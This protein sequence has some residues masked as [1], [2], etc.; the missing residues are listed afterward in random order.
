VAANGSIY[1]LDNN[2][3]QVVE[4]TSSGRAV[5]HWPAPPSSTL[6]S[7]HVLALADGRVLVTDPGGSILLYKRPGASAVRLNLVLPANGT[8]KQSLLGISLSKKGSLL[9]TDSAG[10]RVLVFKVPRV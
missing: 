7:A 5:A 4:M 6:D 3:V 2:N 1:V 8:R 10:H 9:A